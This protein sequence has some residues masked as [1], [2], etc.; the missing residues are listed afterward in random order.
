MAV[1]YLES[2]PPR[3]RPAPSR[4]VHLAGGISFVHGREKGLLEFGANRPH[5][6]NGRLIEPLVPKSRLSAPLN[7]MRPRL[8]AIADQS[9]WGEKEKRRL[10]AP[11][12][13][14]ATALNATKAPRNLI[15]ACDLPYLTAE[16]LDRLL[17]RASM[18]GILRRRA[19]Q[20][21]PSPSDS[22]PPRTACTAEESTKPYTHP[23][24]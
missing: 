15:L 21:R 8:R 22:I 12:V 17:V 20:A 7:A 6:S 2:L 10:R 24:L 5:Y 18:P 13:G 9:F 1:R 16:W 11:L 4:C 14:I 19:R 3:E 23:N